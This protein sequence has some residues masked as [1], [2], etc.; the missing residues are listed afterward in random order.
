[1]PCG[2]SD[3][4]VLVGPCKLWCCGATAS[5]GPKVQVVDE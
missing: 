5:S 4:V 1:M 3:V 2:G